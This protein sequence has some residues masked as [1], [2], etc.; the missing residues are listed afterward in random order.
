[1]EPK[2]QAL[3]TPEECY[4]FIKKYTTLINQARQRAVELRTLNHSVSSEVEAELY[5]VLYAYE[6]ILSQKNKK[7]TRAGRTWQMVN[8]YG[9]IGTA[10]RAVNRKIEPQGYKLLAEF[11]M[12]DLTF[13]AV[14]AK[15]PE[16]FSHEAVTT[17][18]ARLVEFED[19]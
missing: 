8:R 2:I 16:A 4:R 9:I 1:M 5:R 7:R 6:E 11:G 18:K 3:K 14:I 15:Y 17:A 13:E 19:L 10:E 12:K